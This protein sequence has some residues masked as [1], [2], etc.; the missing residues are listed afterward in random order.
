MNKLKNIFC[1]KDYNYF[2]IILAL[3]LTIISQRFTINE[4]YDDSISR[5]VNCFKPNSSLWE[6]NHVEFCEKTFAKLGMFK[7]EDG[8]KN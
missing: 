3:L 4:L 1:I 2:V 7:K 5:F 6:E 8:I